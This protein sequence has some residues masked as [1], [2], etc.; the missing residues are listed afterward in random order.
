MMVATSR[1]TGF[2]F[3]SG[4]TRVK[5]V[6]PGREVAM[7]RP[8]LNPYLTFNGNARE[9]M[10][11]YQR[12]L[13]GSLDLQTFEEAGMDVADDQRQRIVHARLDADGM[14]LM[15]SDSAPGQA[16][17]VGENVS[18]SVSGSDRERMTRLFEDLSEG[19]RVTMPMAEQFWGDTFGMLTDRYGIHWMVD[20]AAE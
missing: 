16:V 19:G 17:Q 13:G 2:R 1:E 15:A 7:S 14:T 10:G 9:A 3:P 6:R 18:L 8:M 11:L 4:E 20:I 12:V 5:M